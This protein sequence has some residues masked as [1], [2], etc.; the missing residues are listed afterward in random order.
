MPDKINMVVTDLDGTLLD[1]DSRLS[2]VNWHTLVKLGEMGIPRVVATG[3]NYFSFSRLGMNDLPIDYLVFSSGGGIMDFRSKH[4]IHS[5]FIP[6]PEVTM[7]IQVLI[8]QNISFMVHDLVPDNH[9]FLFYDCGRTDTDFHKR[10]ELYRD[11]AWPLKLNPPN[12]HHACQILAIVPQDVELLEDLR[13]KLNLFRVIR[14]TSPIDGKSM[15][16]EIFPGDVSKG[17]GI[18]WLCGKLGI[19][20]KECLGIGNDYNDLDMLEVVGHPFVVA[21]APE[22][23]R[24]IF[25]QVSSHT[26]N[27]FTEAVEKLFQGL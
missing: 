10:I 4:I 2:Q 9:R 11:H 25:P 26:E 16:I 23:L 8:K 24:D 6:D 3:R 7:I 19:H 14:T 5:S 1:K 13:D 18:S 21:N 15:W 27:G 12:F 17:H 20:E 22:E